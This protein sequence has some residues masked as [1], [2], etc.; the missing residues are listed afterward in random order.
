MSLALSAS[1]AVILLRTSRSTQSKGR[2]SAASVLWEGWQLVHPVMESSE[3]EIA[4]LCTRASGGME[5]A[6]SVP[7]AV[8]LSQEKSLSSRTR[9]SDAV[10][11][12]ER[13]QPLALCAASSARRRSS[14]RD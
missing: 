3:P 11:V 1:C 9:R 8:F 12:T 6:S 10:S 13:N 5:T 14:R 2:H 7:S 4:V